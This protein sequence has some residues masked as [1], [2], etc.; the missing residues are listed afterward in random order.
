MAF[1]KTVNCN[2][3]Y[4][5]CVFALLYSHLYAIS[6][7]THAIWPSEDIICIVYHVPASNLQCAL[8]FPMQSLE[9]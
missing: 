2:N 7:K 1:L 5:D 4:S 9:V 6:T 8:D 3:I